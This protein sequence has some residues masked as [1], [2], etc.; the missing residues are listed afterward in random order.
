LADRREWVVRTEGSRAGA[1][2][3]K[4]PR[5]RD[6]LVVHAEA[7]EIK[8]LRDEVRNEYSSDASREELKLRVERQDGLGRKAYDDPVPPP[9]APS[10]RGGSHGRI[11]WT[12]H[13]FQ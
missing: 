12:A 9:K 5:R 3:V 8:I 4:A 1:P 7:E 10:K 13:F 2:S 6:L 11:T